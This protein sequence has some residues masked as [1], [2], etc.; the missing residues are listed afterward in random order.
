MTAGDAKER[1][2]HMKVH[3][4]AEPTIQWQSPMSALVD[5]YLQSKSP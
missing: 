1:K 5:D 3:T 2:G 4:I